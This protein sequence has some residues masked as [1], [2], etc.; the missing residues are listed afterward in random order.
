MKTN[1]TLTL[2]IACAAAL[3]ITGCGKSTDA[4]VKP[5]SAPATETA[6]SLT[7]KATDT[8]KDVAVKATEA[9]KTV[10]AV[11]TNTVSAVSEPFNDGIASA[12]KLLAEKNYQGALTELNKLSSL[13]L[14]D[15]QTKV[16]DGL[17]ADAQAMISKATG[18][19]TDAVKGLLGK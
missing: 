14:T 5:E 8:A 11:A 19:A 1:N 2:A 15:E 17:K 6:K 13:K 18:S 12:K 3:T 7:E 16:V 9:V 10:A 4:P